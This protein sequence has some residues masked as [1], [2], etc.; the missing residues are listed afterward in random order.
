KPMFSARQWFSYGLIVVVGAGLLFA[1]WKAF[2]P[3]GP[4]SC[5]ICGRPVHL[6][7]RVDGTANG[8][9][10]TFCCGACALR[11]EEQGD[12]T[13][14]I[15]R[16]Y[17]YETGKALSPDDAVAVVGSEI[18]LCMREHVL[19][20]SHKEASELMFDRCSPSVLSFRSAS[21]AEAFQAKHGG[22]VK[23]FHDVAALVQ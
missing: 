19:M 3:E 18:N 16:V 17:D 12:R 23:P 4:P 11:S 9:S 20:N 13:L 1:G 21:A 5:S 22:V 15:T 14:Q 7:S 10:L 2:S 6:A 8:K